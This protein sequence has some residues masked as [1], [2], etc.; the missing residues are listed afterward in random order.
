M[1]DQIIRQFHIL[2]LLPRY[3]IIRLTLLI[4]Q[5]QLLDKGFTVGL[6]TLQRD[7]NALRDVFVGID[8]CR[9]E[10][11]S[12]SWLSRPPLFN[13]QHHLLSR[14]DSGILSV[15]SLPKCETNL[16][17]KRLALLCYRG[18]LRNQSRRKRPAYVPNCR[19]NYLSSTTSRFISQ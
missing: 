10:D 15:D 11:R 18:K 19:I 6:R 5:D 16:V 12:V 2:N 14:C 1:N 8:N 17:F 4:L 7:L 13:P 9:N 3:P